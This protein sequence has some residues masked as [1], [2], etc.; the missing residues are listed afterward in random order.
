MKDESQDQSWTRGLWRVS[1]V[2]EM[3]EFVT[4]WDLVQQVVLTDRNDEIGW[5]WSADG[6]Y[7]SKLA[8]LAR[9]TGSYATFQG[10][11]IW[12]A[13]AEGKTQILCMALGAKQNTH[14]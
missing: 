6:A 4:L 12:K 2:K 1:T 7:S 3:A 8:Y 5:S 10:N 14:S 11:D 9:F 13:H